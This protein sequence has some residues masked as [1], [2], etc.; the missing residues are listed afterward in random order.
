MKMPEPDGAIRIVDV[1]GVLAK[2]GFNPD[3]PRDELGRWTSDGGSDTPQIR[4]AQIAVP[5]AGPLL[6]EGFGEEAAPLVRPMPPP[7][8]LVGPT[9][10]PTAQPFRAQNPYPNKPKCVEEWAA[11]MKFCQEML[12][13]G[14]LGK[15][16]ARPAGYG[17][18]FNKCL[19]GQVSEECGGNPTSYVEA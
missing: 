16:G 1:D 4:T 15:K 8:D 7:T 10:I 11:A 12:R 14:K 3:E 9:V 17:A 2:S 5:W 18:N 6:G 13:K 19:L